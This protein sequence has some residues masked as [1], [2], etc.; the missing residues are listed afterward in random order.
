MARRKELRKSDHEGYLFIRWVLLLINAA[1]SAGI[2]SLSR[3]RLHGLLFMSFASARYY[4]IKPLRLRAQRTEHGPY[5]RAAHLALG[6]L[7]LSGLINVKDFSAHPSPRDLQFEASFHPTAKGLKV[8]R[9]LRDTHTG[10]SLYRF[11]LDIC[12]GAVIATPELSQ[13]EFSQ[14]NQAFDRALEQDLT[15][16]QAIRRP[17][18][19]LLME[20][21]PGE[22]TPTVKG[23][24]SIDRHIRNN[25]I[26]SSAF[27]NSNNE[28][29]HVI[30]G[31]NQNVIVN[32][33]EVISAYQK[34]L[35]T[36]IA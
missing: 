35:K 3:H 4:N 12:L 1:E 27:E 10:E 29:A 36:R 31:A 15:Y 34:L 28:I 32:K 30:S 2:D 25:L 18:Q 22:N 21:I 19:S 8:G 17:G 33:R 5:Y 9:V 26:H 14:A 7:A 24:K 23:L 11:L 13:A 20:E 6:N 16:Q